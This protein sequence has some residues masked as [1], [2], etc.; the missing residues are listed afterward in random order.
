MLEV[1]IVLQLVIKSRYQK[2]K[3]LFILFW[4]DPFRDDSNALQ[5]RIIRREKEAQMDH[6]KGTKKKVASQKT[7]WL[8]GTHAVQDALLN[9]KRQKLRL[10]V[11]RNAYNRLKIPIEKADVQPEVCTARKF[12][13][14]LE[15]GSVHQGAAL[16]TKPL[17]WGPLTKHT[18]SKDRGSIL[19][20]LLDQIT[21]PQNVGAILRSAE[22]FGATAVV[23]TI[24]H[25][26]PETGALAKSASGALERQPYV[27]VRNLAESIL[28]L[29]KMGFIVLGL[30][31]T[32]KKT[33]LEIVKYHRNRPTALV[34]GAEGSG[35]RSRTKKTVD[36]LVSIPSRN[37][38]GSLNVSNAA[39]V[40][41]YTLRLI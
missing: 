28:E 11:T 25:G 33:V 19:L 41:L 18:I 15:D 3:A 35:L 38:F 10:I 21:D 34:F 7:I 1:Y 20:V 23:S 5:E 12:S 31:E 27:R 22:V 14:P 30:D 36:Q 6:R 32:A 8:F 26:A 37:C 17:E 39:A 16:E 13:A 24:R 40:A 29:Q 2:N 9:N 4:S